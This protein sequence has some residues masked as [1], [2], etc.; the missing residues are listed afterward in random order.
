MKLHKVE[1]KV[2]SRANHSI[3]GK[4]TR[5]KY[6]CTWNGSLEHTNFIK[7]NVLNIPKV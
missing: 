4:P 3:L 6:W 2:D 7:Y 5:K 1:M